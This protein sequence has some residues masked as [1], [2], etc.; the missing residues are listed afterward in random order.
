MVA[1]QSIRGRL[2]TEEDAAPIAGALIVFLDANGD[3]IGGTLSDDAGSYLLRAPA[4]GRYTIRAERI[5][6]AS[7]VSAPLDLVAG[8]TVMHRMVSSA[9][10]IPLDAI[11]VT[12]EVRCEIRPRAGRSTHTLWEEA[13]KAL[14]ATAWT[15]DQDLFRYRSVRYERALDPETLDIREQQSQTLTGASVN[16]FAAISPEALAEEGYASVSGTDGVFYAPDAS[17]LL[18]DSFLD[19]HCFHVVDAEGGERHLIGLAFEPVESRGKPDVRGVL[20]LDR[21]TADLERLNYRYTGLNLPVDDERVGG[22]VTFE[23]LPNG[24]WINR[25]WHI[26]MPI[27]ATETV[28]WLNA[29][30]RQSYYL[31]ALK[32]E[33]GEVLEIFTRAGDVVRSDTVAA[34]QFVAIVPPRVESMCAAGAPGSVTGVVVNSVTSIPLA[35]AQVVVSRETEPFREQMTDASGRYLFCGLPM[36]GDLSIQARAGV[37]SSTRDDLDLFGAWATEKDLTLALHGASVTVAGQTR[38]RATHQPVRLVGVVMDAETLQPIAGAVVVVGGTGMR[39]YADRSG[40]FNVPAVR[41]GIY[42]LEISHPGY[43]SYSED[44]AVG[45]GMSM[46]IEVRMARPLHPGAAWQPPRQ[47]RARSSGRT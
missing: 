1:A 41:P 38:L 31:Q 39:T 14:N 3:Q 6:F 7:V 16:P 17:V 40:R 32:E 43:E 12:S 34:D 5:G 46:E 27:I 30:S 13:R 2:V 26:R 21:E 42:P 18:S 9:S 22:S 11:V 20:W 4:A 25:R 28:R 36:D 37:A 23:R 15:E 19:R 45:G 8:E 10:A 44:I 47:E 24:A 29:S 33:G 35:G